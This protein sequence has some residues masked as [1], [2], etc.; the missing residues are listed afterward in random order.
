MSDTRILCKLDPSPPSLMPAV[1]TSSSSTQAHLHPSTSSEIPTLQSESQFHIPISST[2]T[3]PGNSL[4]TSV[5]SL[6][7]E[8]RIFP[9]TSN[10]FVALSTGVQPSVPLP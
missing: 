10:K 7:T 9:T 8:T 1:S 2:T 5:S 6:S 4:N 3:S